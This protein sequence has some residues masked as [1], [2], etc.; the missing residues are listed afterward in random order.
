MHIKDPVRGPCQS[1]VDYGNTKTTIKH[2]NTKTTK[3]VLKVS[4]LWSWTQY[5]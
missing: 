4:D 5:G 3:H 2:G 1:C